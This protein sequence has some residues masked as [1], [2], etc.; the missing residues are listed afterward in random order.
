MSVLPLWLCDCD[1]VRACAGRALVVTAGGYGSLDECFEILTLLQSGKIDHPKLV[2]VV[3]FPGSYWRRMVNWEGLVESGVISEGDVK[4]LHFT[5]D[6]DDAVDHITTKLGQWE[7]AVAASAVDAARAAALHPPALSPAAEANA[8]AI[9][10]VLA[11]RGD[12]GRLALPPADTPSGTW[13]PALNAATVN[14]ARAHQPIPLHPIALPGSG[15]SPTVDT[16]PVTRVLSSSR[17]ASS[18]GDASA[19]AGVSP[20][21]TGLAALRVSSSGG[22]SGGATPTG[23]AAAAAAARAS[24]ALAAAMAAAGTG[25][26]AD[27]A[28]GLVQTPDIIGVLGSPDPATD[29]PSAVRVAASS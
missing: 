24:P 25:G 15:A 3:M 28:V 20:T 19:T 2:P 12:D 1:C 16:T 11:A 27:A 22:G 14:F 17:S 5:D 8:A 29:T 9:R 26:V 23:A 18:G 6:I 10:A 4:M 21:G 13:S 7:E